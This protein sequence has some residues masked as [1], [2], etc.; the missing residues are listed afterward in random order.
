MAVFVLAKQFLSREVRSKDGGCTRKVGA[1]IMNNKSVY[2]LITFS[3]MAI[4]IGCNQQVTASY[5][6]K[7]GLLAVA[8]WLLSPFLCAHWLSTCLL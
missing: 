4:N 2:K 7:A 8:Q 5:F 6:L 3:F 1:T